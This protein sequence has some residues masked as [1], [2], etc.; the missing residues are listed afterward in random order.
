[1]SF[2]AADVGINLGPF[3]YQ[4]FFIPQCCYYFI[5][6]FYFIVTVGSVQVS[7]AWLAMYAS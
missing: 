5:L 2:M 3:M 6:L 4:C 7:G 1:M